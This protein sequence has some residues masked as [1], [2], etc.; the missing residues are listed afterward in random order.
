MSPRAL[1]ELSLCLYAY[2]SSPAGTRQLAR[3]AVAPKVAIAPGTLAALNLADAIGTPLP[4]TDAAR[5]PAQRP[6]DGG[7]PDR[8]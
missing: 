7:W 1:T 4:S 8:W 3:I 5:C 6:Y 2:A